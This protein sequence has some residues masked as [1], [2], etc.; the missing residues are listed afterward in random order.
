MAKKK[1]Q[2]GKACKRSG[3]ENPPST[4]IDYEK[5]ASC[6]A[7]AIAE[8]NDK[9][10]NSYS[11]TREWMKVII[12]PVFWIFSAL[13]ALFGIASIISAII[14][15]AK[16]PNATNVSNLFGGIISFM[17][18]LICSGT[19]LLALFAGKEFDQEKDRKF[20]VAVFSGM[21]SLVALIVSLVALFRR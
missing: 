14:F 9:R 17:L 21:V 20:V 7:K 15:F 19:A 6:V 4:V 16:L 13:M 12:C 2:K 1:K 3:L 11:I 5:L 18:C 8:E 10:T